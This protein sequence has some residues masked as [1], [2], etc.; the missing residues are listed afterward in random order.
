MKIVTFYCRIL[1][2]IVWSG[3]PFTTA[4]WAAD[5]S[6]EPA[7]SGS[8]ILRNVGTSVPNYTAYQQQK[9]IAAVRNTNITGAHS[10]WSV[11]RRACVVK[12][13][14]MGAVTMFRLI[15]K[16]HFVSTHSSKVSPCAHSSKVSLCAHSSKVSPCA[17]TAVLYKNNKSFNRAQMLLY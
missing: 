10:L 17:H 13:Q 14:W 12:W 11:T 8:I 6:G 2:K 5:V 9:T 15:F 7:G 3:E 16:G 4:I 1:C